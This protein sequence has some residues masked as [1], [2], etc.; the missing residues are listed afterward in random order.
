MVDRLKA[1]AEADLQQAYNIKQKQ[2]RMTAVDEVRSKAFAELITADM[3]TVAQNDVKDVFHS[4]E[5]E[6]GA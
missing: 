6:H 4:L 5:A 3:D 1:L 2:A